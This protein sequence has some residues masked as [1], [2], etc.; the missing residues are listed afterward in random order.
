MTEVATVAMASPV[1][2]V[3]GGDLPAGDRAAPACDAALEV[4]RDVEAQCSRFD[5]ASD[6]SLVN[7]APHRWH[8]VGRYCYAAI[9]E[10]WS[11]Y[12]WTNGVFD[13]RVLADLVALGYDRW[14]PRHG[15][16]S[17]ED[18]APGAEGPVVARGRWHPRFVRLVHAVR[19]G[20]AGV[21]LGGIAKGL[22]VRWASCALARTLGRSDHLIDAGGDCYCAGSAPGG[23]RWRIGVE[24]PLGGD[25]PLAVLALCDQACTTSSVQRRHWV[26]AGH[27]VHHLIDPSTSRPGGDGLLAVTV[28]GADPAIAEVWSKVLFLQGAAGIDRAAERHGVACC[29]VT[30][31]GALHVNGRAQ[32]HVVWRR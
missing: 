19:V 9:D 25:V 4:F 8:H 11:A 28:I 21:D 24:D 13:P 14:P 32:A 15:P 1:R 2:V 12:R 17:T 27:A 22:A 20:A 3:I 18:P 29:W 6:L 23:G 5:Q 26:S 30:D 10:A 31:D 7:R 16:G